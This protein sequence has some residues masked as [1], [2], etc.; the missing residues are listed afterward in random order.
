MS[1][2]PRSD[3]SSEEVTGTDTPQ[4]LPSAPRIMSTSPLMT[5]RG[6]EDEDR[7]RFEAASDVA[8]SPLMS[9]GS[10]A[11]S[12][13]DPPVGPD[14]P[15]EHTPPGESRGICVLTDLPEVLTR[16]LVLQLRR[17]YAG[18]ILAVVSSHVGPWDSRPIFV[19]E[20]CRGYRANPNGCT[21]RGTTM[22]WGGV[23]GASWE[24]RA[25]AAY[26][27]VALNLPRHPESRSDVPSF[28]QD[29]VS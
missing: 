5:S 23:T 7:H 17:T 2:L 1:T 24:H 3:I 9:G 25:L 27:L 18:R 6:D 19:A 29:K 22:G 11:L 12:T 28:Y 4:A 8:Q 21:R 20:R 14:R 10:A 13:R 15:T 16:R 26:I